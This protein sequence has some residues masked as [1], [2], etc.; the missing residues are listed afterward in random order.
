MKHT[1]FI[2][3]FAVFLS[4]ACEDKRAIS[5]TLDINK[6]FTVIENLELK[7]FN[8]YDAVSYYYLITVDSSILWAFD[9]ENKNNIGSCYDLNT[10]EKLSTIGTIGNAKYEFTTFPD[11]YEI[12]ED[13]IQF[14]IHGRYIKT[15][16]I[17]DILENKPM[18]ERRFSIT[19][20]PDSIGVWRVI[21]LP[22]NSVIS[23]YGSRSGK[24]I[25][26][27]QVVVFNDSCATYYDLINYESP[28]IK[29]IIDFDPGLD[30]D[31]KLCYT[32]GAIITNGNDKAV[33][34][35]YGQFTLN[36][37]DLKSKKVIKEKKFTDFM[38][39]SKL[40]GAII[41][42]PIQNEIKSSENVL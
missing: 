26:E 21:K 36:L 12:V 39:V 2:L 32:N 8:E 38:L 20:A 3:I 16:L 33:V 34:S 23:L 10:G 25:N 35:V 15:C 1:H 31:L 22:N 9:L 17:S 7:H 37:L 4:L 29:E 11:S 40:P 14:F 13:S 19:T 27:K 5:T 30:A 24:N 42:E 18:G 41:S 6:E 28:D